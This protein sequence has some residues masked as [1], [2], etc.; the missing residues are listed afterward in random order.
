[1][2]TVRSSHSLAISNSKNMQVQFTIDGEIQL[3]RVLLGV[4]A[5]VKDWTPALTKSGEDLVEV[6]SYDAFETEGAVYGE[7]W[8]QLS[9]AYAKRKEKTFPGMGILEATGLMRD[10]FTQMIDP[11]SLT[12]GN[13]SEYFKYHQSNQP[14]TKLPRRVMMMLTQALKETVV[15]N[16][17]TQLLEKVGTA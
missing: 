3:S 2:R 4:S 12:I 1:M 15:K 11:T 9:P 7:P 6:F 14:R 5:A 13:A 16:F 8:E 17:Q 10:S